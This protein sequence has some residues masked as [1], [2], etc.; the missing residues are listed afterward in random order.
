MVGVAETSDGFLSTITCRVGFSEAV[1][2]LGQRVMLS[3]KIET[4]TSEGLHGPEEGQVLNNLGESFAGAAGTGSVLVGRVAAKS[5]KHFVVYASDVGWVGDWEQA[6]R[7]DSARTMKV[8]AVEDPTWSFYFDLVA[9]CR[10]GASDMEL[11]NQLRALDRD[12]S[13]PRRID[14]NFLYPNEA[15]AR[16]AGREAES[17]GFSV[18]VLEGS[19]TDDWVVTL[20][21]TEPLPLAYVVHMTAESLRFSARTGGRYDGWGAEVANARA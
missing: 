1:P 17:M 4:P 18:S 16:Q 5:A 12:L 19:A 10:Q 3:A 13:I 15:S 6:V 21:S 9:R 7:A 8:G 14:W 20:S 2:G 11:Y